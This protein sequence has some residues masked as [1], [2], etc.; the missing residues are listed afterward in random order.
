VAH[1]LFPFYTM[2]PQGLLGYKANVRVWVPMDDEHTMFFMCSRANAFRR[3]PAAAGEDRARRGLMGGAAQENSTD[4]FGR[5][6][7][8]ANA[9][10][11]F[12]IDRAAQR[13][14]ESYTGIAGIHLQDQAITE[15]M[16]TIY[17]RGHEHLGT[18]DGMVIR[19][20]R[21]LIAAA[22]ALDK[23]GITPPGVDQPE[24]YGVR[25]GGVFLPDGTEWL[26]ATKDLR[27]SFLSHEGLDPTITGAIV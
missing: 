27:R 10:N 19:V 5:F 18:S 20:R 13:R 4:W 12:Q 23:N 17:D 25:S 16:G 14:S 26:E 3:P 22:K 7:L 2:P 21:R 6:R 1:W 8:T 24:V 11:D 9:A 15:S